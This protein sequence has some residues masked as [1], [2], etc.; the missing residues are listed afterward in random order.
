MVAVVEVQLTSTIILVLQVL[1][2]VPFS[3]LEVVEQDVREAM[4]VVEVLEVLGGHM[5]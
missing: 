5:P 4:M 3:L 1:A 2:V